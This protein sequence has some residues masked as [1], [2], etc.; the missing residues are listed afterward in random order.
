MP[1]RIAIGSL[2]ADFAWGIPA[3]HACRM[4]ELAFQFII[5]P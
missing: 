1:E 2:C 3:A 4:R 5:L